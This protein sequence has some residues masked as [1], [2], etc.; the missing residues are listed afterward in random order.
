VQSDTTLRSTPDPVG[1][2]ILGKAARQSSANVE[3][4]TVSK[5]FANGFEAVSGVGLK[6][7]PGEFFTV[8]G[9][10]GSGKSTLLRMIAGLESPSSGS[11]HIG[12]LDVTGLS[13]R[14]RSVAMV[15][16]NPALYPHLSVF[17][18]LAFSLRARGSRGVAVRA[19]VA[20]VASS[21]GIEDLLKRR[22]GSLSGGQKQRVAL[23]RAIAGRPGVFLLDEP[24]SSLDGPLRASVRAELVELHRSSG[25]TFLH[26][27]HDQAEALALGDRLGV[28]VRGRLVQVGTPAEVY[29]NPATRFVG[30]FLGSPPMT[31]VRCHVFDDANGLRV[32]PTGLE[33]GQ[34]LRIDSPRWMNAVSAH[35]G[36]TVDL[37]L[38]PENLV[39]GENGIGLAR[40]PGD[41]VVRRIEFLGHELIATVELGPHLLNVR[42]APGSAVRTGDRLSLGVALDAVSWFV[43]ETGLAL[44]ADASPGAGR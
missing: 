15:F 26:V 28:M 34:S 19:R 36:R 17:D 6:V 10:S 8:V 12:G 7:D 27:T 4:R 20:E 35:R 3:L 40:M 13:P 9:P 37:G 5:V 18:N 31:V 25:A 41:L 30:E 32:I 11:V 1:D 43:P 21:L 44:R 33:H 39:T 16:Q 23:G 38:R 42:L 24:L 22:P 14:E 29:K 2:P